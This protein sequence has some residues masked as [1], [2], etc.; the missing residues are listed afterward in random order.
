M[1]G[2][3]LYKCVSIVFMKGILPW[4]H[5][6]IV[7]QEWDHAQ[8]RNGCPQEN[9]MFKLFLHWFTVMFLQMV[10]VYCSFST[11]AVIPCMDSWTRPL[12]N[13]RFSIHDIFQTSARR[14]CLF[15]SSW[16]I[17]LN[18]SYIALEHW[19]ATAKIKCRFATDVVTFWCFHTKPVSSRLFDFC[20]WW[21]QKLQVWNFPRTTI[22]TKEL[23]FGPTKRRLSQS[24]LVHV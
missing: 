24:G 5:T 1:E 15:E 4:K 8:D 12:D 10:S 11:Q 18:S 23:I 14:S 20:V 19:Y 6:W 21:E 3:G 9:K 22:L 17:L 13:Q 7:T 16:T 2:T